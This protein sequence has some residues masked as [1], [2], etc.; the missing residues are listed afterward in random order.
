VGEKRKASPESAPRRRIASARE[1][2]TGPW[3]PSYPIERR[4]SPSNTPSEP[5][6]SKK[7]SESGRGFFSQTEIPLVDGRWPAGIT[8][9]PFLAEASPQALGSPRYDLQIRGIYGPKTCP[10]LPRRD[11]TSSTGTGG[12]TS[13]DYVQDSKAMGLEAQ[14]NGVTLIAGLY[15]LGGVVD[16]NYPHAVTFYG[17]REEYTPSP[18]G[19]SP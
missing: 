17:Y 16:F 6:F 4:T 2:L 18:S 3:R 5:L 1:I 9:F 7:P 13:G 12:S 15:C 19:P 14:E 10:V 8:C 11:S